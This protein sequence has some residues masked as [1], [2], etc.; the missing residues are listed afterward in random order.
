MP[1]YFV[2]QGST[3]PIKI[4]RAVELRRRIGQLQTGN[5]VSL[6]LLGWLTTGNDTT[7]EQA[8]HKHYAD[9]RERGEWFSITQDHA[10]RELTLNHGFVP[11][12]GDAFEIIGHD[13]DG[14]P[15][16]A[17]A[18]EWADFEIYE[19]CPFC[20]CLCGMHEVSDLPLYTCMSCGV[21]TDFSTLA[22]VDG[23]A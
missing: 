12:R 17:G 4:G 2:R 5:P 13:K 11:K 8:L 20:G 6:E 9:S 19:C 1:V 21:L 3:G 14:I 18:C 7:T 23:D 15:E 22:R 16:F 10:L